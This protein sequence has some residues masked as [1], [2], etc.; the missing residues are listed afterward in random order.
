[1]LTLKIVR[2][3]TAFHSSTRPRL[4]ERHEV[5]KGH[6]EKSY[7]FVFFEGFVSFQQAVGAWK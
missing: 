6:G 2:A 1:M 7:V 3:S 5:H 4:L